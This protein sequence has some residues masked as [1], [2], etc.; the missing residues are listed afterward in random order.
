[1]ENKLK[2]LPGELGWVSCCKRFVIKI[3][4]VFLER[5][6]IKCLNEVIPQ[7]ATL[8]LNQTKLTFN[9]IHR[10]FQ[11]PLIF[12]MTFIWIRVS[13]IYSIKNL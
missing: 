13:T 3:C 11:W 1:M 12:T 8:G 2:G 7:L 10:S 4:K 9:V 6:S 5:P